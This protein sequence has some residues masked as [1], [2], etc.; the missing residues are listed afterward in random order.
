MKLNFQPVDI[1]IFH[2]TG[3]TASRHWQACPWTICCHGDFDLFADPLQLV[4]MAWQNFSRHNKANHR[5]ETFARSIHLDASALGDFLHRNVHYGETTKSTRRMSEEIHSNFSEIMSLLAAGTNRQFPVDSTSV[6]GRIHGMCFIS[7][8]QHSM[9]RK[10][11]KVSIFIAIDWSPK[12]DFSSRI[13]QIENTQNFVIKCTLI[14]T[15]KIGW[16]FS[17]KRASSMHQSTNWISCKL[18]LPSNSSKRL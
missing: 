14:N 10:T 18:K 17:F 13:S 11:T 15:R 5:S 9:L 4:Q 7:M 12:I 2:P 16:T 1:E 6:P 3:F 8:G